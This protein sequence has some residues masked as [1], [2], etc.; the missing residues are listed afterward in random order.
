VLTAHFS[1]DGASVLTASDDGTARL[2]DART[3]QPLAEPMRH[4]SRINT[5]RFSPDGR[6]TVTASDD[7]TAKLWEIPEMPQPIPV[8]LPEAAEAVAGW[9]RNAQGTLEYV[10]VDSRFALRRRL[11]ISVGTNSSEGRWLGWFL[12]D[13]DTRR[14]SPAHS[15]RVSH[16][17]RARLDENTLDSL[18]EAARLSPANGL[19]LA[20]LARKLLAPD[21]T[22]NSRA[23]AEADL[24]SRRALE[25]APEEEEAW[26]VREEVLT[27]A[28]NTAAALEKLESECVRQ[29]HSARLWNLKGRLLEKTARLEDAYQAY[30]Q[31]LSWINS[32]NAPSVR[33]RHKVLLDRVRVLRRL[34]RFPEAAAD[35]LQALAI[36]PREASAPPNVIDL[37]AYYNAATHES[38]QAPGSN[39]GLNALPTGLSALGGVPFDLRGIVQ[40]SGREARKYGHSYPESVTDIQVGQ[41]CRRLRFLHATGWI[42]Q[43]GTA[44]GTY[45]IHYTDGHQEQWPIVYGTNLQDWWVTSDAVGKAS[46]AT[47]AW[48]GKTPGGQEVRLYA[49]HWENP[50]PETQVKSIDFVSTMSRSAPFLIAITAE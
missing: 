15:L 3:G 41:H 14:I 39:H 23:A 37:S 26:S 21:P 7:H 44:V 4:S 49:D 30:N 22:V 13:R 47:V 18:Y 38:W 33:L 28:G 10:P 46:H 8:W 50:R 31:A 6:W 32:S 45:R 9:R 27:S 2:W 24:Y 29:P 42:E 40:L 17:V 16:Y 35:N 1:R 36:P 20:R 34:H 48:Q 19:V 5:A 43:D 25:L 12:A 11:E